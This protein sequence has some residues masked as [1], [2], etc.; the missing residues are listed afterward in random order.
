MTMPTA[1]NPQFTKLDAINALLLT[2]KEQPVASEE[3]ITYSEA[4]QAREQLQQTL[5][6]VLS[7]RWTFNTQQTNLSP[8]AVN[9]KVPLPINTLEA[10]SY[11]ADKTYS[12]LN[13]FL[14]HNDEN[15]FEFSGAQT[16]LLTLY[17][18]FDDLPLPLRF[19]ITRMASKAFE[20]RMRG[21]DSVNSWLDE[22]ITRA[23]ARCEAFELRH[24]R[25]LMTDNY[26]HSGFLQDDYNPV[27]GKVRA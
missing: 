5:I 16:V 2:I 4:Y 23:R 21:S 18:E 9:N 13:G 19:L 14:Y 26:R 3:D 17:W 24:R 11:Y 8:E 15:T 7:E 27:K 12:A 22:E 6:E 25:P 10:R 1:V 20:K